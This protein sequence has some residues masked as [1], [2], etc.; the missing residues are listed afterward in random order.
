MLGTV[1]PKDKT[2]G[3][4]CFELELAVQVP[5]LLRYATSSS[6]AAYHSFPCKHENSFI[7]LLLLS[8]KSL[9][10]FRGSRKFVPPVGVFA[11]LPECSSCPRLRR[12]FV[13]LGTLLS[14][15]YFPEK[16]YPIQ[17]VIQFSTGVLGNKKAGTQM[18]TD[19]LQ[20]DRVPPC[21]VGFT[22]M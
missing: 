8:P 10:T 18:C 12:R 14:W 3:N 16:T 22:F 6:Q 1:V 17:P 7:P 20:K 9:A 11:V 2:G 19:H 15:R 21:N 5:C 13:S 4:A